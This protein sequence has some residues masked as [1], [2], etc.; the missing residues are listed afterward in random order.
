VKK[1]ASVCAEDDDP[2]LLVC[3]A[4]QQLRNA[5]QPERKIRSAIHFLLGGSCK[6][7]VFVF[8]AAH[9]AGMQF[10]N[11]LDVSIFALMYDD[12]RIYVNYIG[13]CVREFVLLFPSFCFEFKLKCAHIGFCS[14]F[15][16]F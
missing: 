10:C 1:A 6:V 15:D 12:I 7:P 8:T 3:T 16:L 14:S 13:L 11:R 2:N 9:L 4:R 5:I